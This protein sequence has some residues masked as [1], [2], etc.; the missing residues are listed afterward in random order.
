MDLLKVLTLLLPYLAPFP[1]RRNETQESNAREEI[2][3]NR[4]SALSA[5]A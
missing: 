1:A 3:P 5:H 2:M 4:D